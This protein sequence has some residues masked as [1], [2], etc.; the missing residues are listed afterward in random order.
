VELAT[1]VL[2]AR[3]KLGSHTLKN[4]VCA[5]HESF[6]HIL[7]VMGKVVSAPRVAYI[8]KRCMR[9]PRLPEGYRG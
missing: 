6:N 2:G 3:Q 5:T 1:W 9:H 8:E 7:R 4:D